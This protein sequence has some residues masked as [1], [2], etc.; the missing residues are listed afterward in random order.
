MGSCHV[1]HADISVEVVV[2]ET[3]SHENCMKYESNRY[4]I[5][6]V[7]NFQFKIFSWYF[8]FCFS[9]CVFEFLQ[10][11][12]FDQK[13]LLST[14]NASHVACDMVFLVVKREFLIYR[15]LVLGGS[16]FDF[17]DSV[18]SNLYRS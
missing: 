4:T 10:Q 16:Q 5:E 1:S 3:L 11:H 8:Q 13:T 2:Q 6:T 9:I 12:A 14:K 7:R 17:P 15:K 18:A